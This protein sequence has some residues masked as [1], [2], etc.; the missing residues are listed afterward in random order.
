MAIQLLVRKNFADLVEEKVSLL[1]LAADPVKFVKPLWFIQ[2]YYE[3]E[4]SNHLPYDVRR[5]PLPH[6]FFPFP[7]PSVPW[8]LITISINALTPFLLPGRLV[9]GYWNQL[10]QFCKVFNFKK[11]GFR[12]LIRS[13]G[14]TIDFLFSHAIIDHHGLTLE[15]FSYEEITANYRPTIGRKTVFT[16]AIGLET[17]IHEIRRCSTKEYYT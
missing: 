8:R 12:S 5:L 16:A 17:N 11:L 6:R 7:T 4:H 9:K 1:S 13:D 10:E 14:F 3:E 2:D 15:D